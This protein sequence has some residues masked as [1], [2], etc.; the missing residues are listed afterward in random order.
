[1]PIDSS[2]KEEAVDK[3]HRRKNAHFQKIMVGYDGS[4][5]GLGFDFSRHWVLKG[6]R[7]G[8][9]VERY[10]TC[11]IKIAAVAKRRESCKCLR[12]S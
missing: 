11:R 4:L 7:L 10:C 6:R 3:P 5:A 12:G 2:G 1:M 8:G 9:K